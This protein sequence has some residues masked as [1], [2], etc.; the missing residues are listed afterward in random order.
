MNNFARRLKILIALAGFCFVAACGGPVPDAEPATPTESASTFQGS[1]NFS[2]SYTCQGHRFVIDQ[3]ITQF[4]QRPFGSPS[5][6]KTTLALSTNQPPANEPVD[7]LNDKVTYLCGTMNMKPL[8]TCGP[9]CNEGVMTCQMFGKPKGT[10]T[11]TFA[12]Y[13]T[14]DPATSLYVPTLGVNGTWGLTLKYLYAP[15]SPG[16]GFGLIDCGTFGFGAPAFWVTIN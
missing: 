6:F 15:A 7:P 9:Y 13:L 10:S 2:G 1:G 11:W 3:P 14:T 4:V 12:G 5:Y 16:N 8:P